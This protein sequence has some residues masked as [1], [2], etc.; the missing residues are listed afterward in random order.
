MEQ[1]IGFIDYNLS[2]MGEKS[3]VWRS[4]NGEWFLNG[5][6]KE[7]R[8]GTVMRDELELNVQGKAATLPHLRFMEPVF[9]Y[10]INNT[11][12]LGY[13]KYINMRSS[14]I[15]LCDNSLNLLH[16]AMVN[17]IRITLL[18]D[19]TLA[20][21]W[22]VNECRKDLYRLMSFLNECYKDKISYNT[23][24]SVITYTP[25]SWSVLLNQKYRSFY[26][27]KTEEQK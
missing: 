8:L 1:N 27:W 18:K 11:V 25:V 7:I 26:Y 9:T 6:D 16:P 5:E 23:V 15:M 3:P 24:V 13:E 17:N 20:E 4:A 10:G 12:R 21:L 19:I 22:L 2:N 14:M